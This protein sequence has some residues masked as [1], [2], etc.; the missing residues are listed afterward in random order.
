MSRRVIA[1]CG[2]GGVG[3]TSICAII[4]S[5][6]LKNSIKKTLMVDADHAGGLALA[7]GVDVKTTLNDVRK[8][9]IAMIKNGDVDKTDL[10]ASVDYR[11]ME[12]LLEKG[13]LAFLSIGRP[14][15]EGCYCSVHTL[16]KEAIE[17]LAGNFDITVIDAEAGIEQM[18]R[19]VMDSVDYLIL[20]SDTSKKGIKVVCDLMEV[21]KATLGPIETGVIFNRVRSQTEAEQLIRQN[22]LPVIGWVNE[23]DTIRKHDGESISFFDLPDCPA[24]NDVKA[25]LERAKII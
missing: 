21:A 10:A 8:K 5:L 24:L 18:N 9:T 25:I 14:E 15:E 2:K 16:L 22:D 7:L 19:K 3:K 6:L 17:H 23:D 20:V 13:N 12:A 1:V 4:A 11:L